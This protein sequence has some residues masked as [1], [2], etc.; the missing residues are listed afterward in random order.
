MNFATL[1]EDLLAIFMLW[2]CL[3]FW[4]QDINIQFVFFVVT[5]KQLPYNLNGPDML[6]TLPWSGHMDQQDCSSFFATSTASDLPSNS[7]CKLK[8]MILFCPWMS[9]SWRRVVNWPWKCKGNL[10]IQAVICISSPTTHIIWKG[11]SFIVW[12]VEPSHMSRSEG[13]QQEN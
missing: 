8:L 11:E 2:F 12:S 10:L 13:F 6:T 3:A 7:Q 4:W 5:S 9:W 1:L